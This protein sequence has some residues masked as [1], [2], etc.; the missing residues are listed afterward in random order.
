MANNCTDCRHYEYNW[1][2]DSDG[3]LDVEWCECAA[4]PNL[5]NLKQFPFKNTQCSK[6]T[7][8]H[9]PTTTQEGE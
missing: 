9:K 1:D 5:G 4:R 8:K 2:S 3:Y 6:F 7:K